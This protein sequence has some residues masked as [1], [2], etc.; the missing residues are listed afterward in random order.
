M[1]RSHG[2]VGCGGE[3]GAGQQAKAVVETVDGGRTWSTRSATGGGAVGRL[4]GSDYLEGISMWPSGTGFL[5]MGRGTT[6]M[7]RDGGR[8][9]TAIGPGSPDVVIP[10]AAATVDDR[11]W[12]AL[13]WDG[14]E[15]AQVLHMT[16]DSGST[17]RRVAEL[18]R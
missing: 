10:L 3:P 17:W 8:T 16:E 2:W 4:F 13:V 7:T 5:W 6:A 18:A 9:W 12:F 15:Q 1:S 11:T 14:N